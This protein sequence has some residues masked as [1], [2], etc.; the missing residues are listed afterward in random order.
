MSEI[1]T[2][3]YIFPDMFGEASFCCQKVVRYSRCYAHNCILVCMSHLERTFYFE[4]F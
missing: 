2:G 4:N 1:S 3:M